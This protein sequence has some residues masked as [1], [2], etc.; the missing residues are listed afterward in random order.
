MADWRKGE[1]R[2]YLAQRIQRNQGPT[3]PQW[4]V[5]PLCVPVNHLLHSVS[6]VRRVPHKHFSACGPL[7]NARR[8]RAG[9]APWRLVVVGYAQ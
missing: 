3:F 8:G 2:K 4:E 1:R 5:G 6:Y 9:S 7:V